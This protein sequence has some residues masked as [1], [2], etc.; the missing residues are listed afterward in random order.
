MEQEY[1]ITITIVTLGDKKDSRE[2]AELMKDELEHN[3][4]G[5]GSLKIAVHSVEVNG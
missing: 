4:N 2:L 3:F 5:D 1:L